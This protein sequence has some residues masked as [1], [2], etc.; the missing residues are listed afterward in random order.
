MDNT[1]MG[2]KD[3]YAL[4]HLDDILIFSDTIREQEKRVEMVFERIRQANFKLKLG[5]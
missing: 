2:L 1:S 4:V 3:I 5:K